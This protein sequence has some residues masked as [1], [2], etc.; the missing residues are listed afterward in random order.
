MNALSTEVA[1]TKH[2]ELLIHT[3]YRSLENLSQMVD[4]QSSISLRRN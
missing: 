2:E 4:F 1:I 3:V